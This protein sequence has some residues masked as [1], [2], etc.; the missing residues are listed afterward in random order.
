LAVL[1]G[2]VTKADGSPLVGAPVKVRLVAGGARVP[3]HLTDHAVA[4]TAEAETDAAG[5]FAIEVPALPTEDPLV[6]PPEAYYEITVGG[7][8]FDKYVRKVKPTD[9]ETY[10]IT[11]PLIGGEDLLPPEF[12]QITPTITSADVEA[13]VLQYFVDNPIDVEDEV[14]AALAADPPF[15][16]ANNLS[17]VTD[18]A[19]ARLAIEAASDTEMD[20]ADTALSNR[21]DAIDAYESTHPAVRAP[22]YTS[23]RFF[24]DDNENVAFEVNGDGEGG[25]S[26]GGTVP[27]GGTTGQ[28]L[29]KASDTDFDTEWD[30]VGGGGGGDVASDTIWDAKGDLAGGTGANAA[31]N[32]TVGANDTILMAASG[33]TTGLKWGTPSVVRAAL[34]L[35]IGTDVQAYDADLTTWAGK[36]APSGA[37]VG[38]TDSQTL[39]NKTL[40]S[41]AVTTPTGIVKGDVGLGNV[42]NTADTAKPVSTAQQ[43]ALD[44]KANLA[45]PTL[46]GTPTA[47]TAAP[48]TNNTQIATTAYA[49]AAVAAGGGGG[50]SFDL[51][52]QMAFGG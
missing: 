46:T 33:E 23:V 45:S 25:E 48:A 8:R 5:N 9:N 40:T 16:V 2:P 18:P 28:A 30:D 43:T 24:L 37:V 1:T 11:D 22:G 42:D 6:Y 26:A 7:G 12:V 38:T 29:V 34:D 47:P 13:I 32:L 15:L 39:T 41:P 31:D 21:L 49:D 20:A 17:E 3:G 10:V 52:Q 35:E 19:A 36:T 27:A 50:G 44:L 51:A 4:G 14:A